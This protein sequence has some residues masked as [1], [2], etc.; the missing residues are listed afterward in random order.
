M[1]Q[2]AM[3][4]TTTWG[5]R[6][7]EL[8]GDVI[9]IKQSLIRSTDSFAANNSNASENGSEICAIVTKVVQGCPP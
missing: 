1:F 5:S 9:A 4:S 8:L 3:I 7:Y 6:S 2:L